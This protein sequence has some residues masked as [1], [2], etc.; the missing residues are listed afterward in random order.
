M[1]ENFLLAFPPE[2][3]K[4]DVDTLALTGFIEGELGVPCP[5]E[6]KEFWSNL[7]SGYFGNRM[8]YFF[9]DDNCSDAR[10]SLIKWNQK[11][12]WPLIYPTPK[13]GGP[14][15]FAETCFGDQLGFRWDNGKCIFL[16]FSVDTFEA[17]VIADT[18]KQ[19]F[20]NLLVDKYVF[21]D[22]QRFEAVLFKLGPLQNGMHYAPL[23]SPMLG[24]MDGAENFCFETPNVHFRTSIATFHA[25][26]DQKNIHLED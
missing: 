10:D 11:D 3:G 13:D 1:F 15:F 12:F 6:L 14:V 17:F 9:G 24:G 8:L 18:G 20:E 5:M 16:L 21:W 22:E 23:I 25:K 4:K 2:T 7:G 26:R 19:L